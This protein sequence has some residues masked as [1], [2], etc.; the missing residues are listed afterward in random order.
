MMEEGGPWWLP[1][2]GFGDTP[3]S[4]LALSPGVLRAGA[5][6]DC[7]LIIDESGRA[8]DSQDKPLQLQA[9]PLYHSD[10]TPINPWEENGQHL[11]LCENQLYF[12][13]IFDSLDAPEGIGVQLYLV[14]KSGGAD[15]SLLPT[16]TIGEFSVFLGAN[17]SFV[18]PSASSLVGRLANTLYI[19]D[20][21]SYNR[22]PRVLAIN[23][24]SLKT[25]MI[26]F[27][28]DI[29]A[30]DECLPAVW[31]GLPHHSDLVNHCQVK[32]CWRFW[33]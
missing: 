27:P 9:P 8:L 18:L 29:A 15:Y 2:P 4:S 1:M 31:V 33:E 16:M 6:K 5:S 24:E 3:L 32:D 7:I 10:G 12:V 20:F 25:L 21:R 30:V 28:E 26:P 11:F 23:F 17:Q 19:E 13:Q 22:R 14:E